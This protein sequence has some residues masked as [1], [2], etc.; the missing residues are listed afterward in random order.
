MPPDG[1]GYAAGSLLAFHLDANVKRELLTAIDLDG[2]DHRPVDPYPGADWNDGRES[3]PVVAVDHALTAS[4]GQEPFAKVRDDAQCHV[5]VSNGASE[6]TPGSA[7]RV[8]VRPVP[9]LD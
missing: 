1:L 8:V 7:L 4:E 9:V 2:L 3:D 5:C 6:R